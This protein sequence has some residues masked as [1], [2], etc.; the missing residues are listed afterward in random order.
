MLLLLHYQS[1]LRGGMAEEAPGRVVL[2]MVPARPV[3]HGVVL[4]RL[5]ADRVLDSPWVLASDVG[6][7]VGEACMGMKRIMRRREIHVPY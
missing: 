7:D 3:L 4:A 2:H 6:A 1:L 5:G